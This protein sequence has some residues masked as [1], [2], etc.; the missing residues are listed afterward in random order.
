MHLR[1]FWRVILAQST[2]IAL[3]LVISAYAL[4]QLTWLTGLNTDILVVDMTFI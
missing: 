2:L 4:S 1:L 3:L